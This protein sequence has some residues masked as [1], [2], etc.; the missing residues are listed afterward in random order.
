MQFS[1]DEAEALSPEPQLFSRLN[2]TCFEVFHPHIPRAHHFPWHD[3]LC[4]CCLQATTA[5]MPPASL[6][7]KA[8]L[9]ST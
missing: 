1:P 4:F 6:T 5:S 8:R 2:T 9:H 7:K 3:T